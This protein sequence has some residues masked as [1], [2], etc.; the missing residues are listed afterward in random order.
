MSIQKLIVVA[1]KYFFDSQFYSI[2]IIQ[3]IIFIAQQ[4]EH[5]ESVSIKFM[6]IYIINEIINNKIYKVFIQNSLSDI[7]I[8][9]CFFYN[10]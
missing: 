3:K 1:G 7:K 10:K 5:L 4:S 2:N 8:Y 9:Y 6:I